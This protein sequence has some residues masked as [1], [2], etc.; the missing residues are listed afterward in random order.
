MTTILWRDNKPYPITKT[1]AYCVLLLIPTR[2]HKT[3]SG[4]IVREAPAH[5]ERLT[6]DGHVVRCH[7]R[8]EAEEAR[9]KLL[10]GIEEGQWLK[11]EIEPYMPTNHDLPYHDWVRGVRGNAM[12]RLGVREDQL[13]ESQDQSLRTLSD[14]EWLA[15]GPR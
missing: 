8:Y 6:S 1:N 2:V 4:L 13:P 15:R 5:W 11:V 10:A 12:E 9:M 7:T 14:E 3:L